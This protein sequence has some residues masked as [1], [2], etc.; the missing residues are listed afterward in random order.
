METMMPD[1]S[2]KRKE[3][4]LIK[5]ALL[6]TNFKKIYTKGYQTLTN[7]PQRKIIDMDVVLQKKIIATDEEQYFQR[8]I[9]RLKN[10]SMDIAF[11]NTMRISSQVES[12]SVYNIRNLLR[13]NRVFHHTYRP[14]LETIGVKK[15]L[16]GIYTP[17]EPDKKD[18]IL[19]GV[20]DYAFQ[21][22][23]FK[24]QSVRLYEIFNR[25][26]YTKTPKLEPIPA[27]EIPLSMQTSPRQVTQ[28]LMKDLKENALLMA[29][30]KMT[31]KK[32]IEIRDYVDGRIETWQP[33]IGKS[34]D[35]QVRKIE[36]LLNEGYIFEVDEKIKNDEK[37]QRMISKII[38]KKDKD[39]KN[40]YKNSTSMFQSPSQSTQA[41][42]GFV[43]PSLTSKINMNAA[44]G[45]NTSMSKDYPQLQSLT[46][47]ARGDDSQLNLKSPLVQPSIDMSQSFNID[48]Q[49]I[50][51]T[52]RDTDIGQTSPIH[53][54]NPFKTKDN[55]SLT[56]QSTA[57]IKFKSYN[58]S[59]IKQMAP[60]TVKNH[61]L[62]SLEQ[63][64]KTKNFKVKKTELRSIIERCSSQE[65]KEMQ[66]INTQIEKI[67]ENY[68]FENDDIAKCLEIYQEQLLIGLADNK[69]QNINQIQDTKRT[70]EQD[71]Y[72]NFL[73]PEIVQQLKSS[74]KQ[75]VRAVIKNKKKTLWKPNRLELNRIV[76]NM[77]DKSEVQ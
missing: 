67:K 58:S 51:I 61:D 21:K 15:L 38:T 12:E 66:T 44:S 16:K 55:T 70:Q 75:R 45:F 29:S 9:Q 46:V 59:P 62:K 72:D 57:R 53:S 69:L 76:K 73:S 32:L 5:E 33:D 65:R 25:S 49:S 17:N 27:T 6:D 71:D 42:S 13:Q 64:F 14:G 11:P 60:K 7:S 10:Q 23:N 26:E 36:E 31:A 43:L 54:I 30:K 52:L 56:L 20:Q 48:D 24:D 4:R 35:L 8:K 19:Q 22:G 40:R 2:E 68:D 28:K 18:E 39:Q 63:E 77:I 41:H 47:S 37:F 50:M 74:D 3:M 34:L 1:Q